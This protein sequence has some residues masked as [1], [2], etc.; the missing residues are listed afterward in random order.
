MFIRLLA[1]LG[2]ELFRP[3]MLV[4]VH[5]IFVLDVNMEELLIGLIVPEP[6]VGAAISPA[7]P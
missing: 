5:F 1:K 4:V 6:D 2:I 3:V 7:L